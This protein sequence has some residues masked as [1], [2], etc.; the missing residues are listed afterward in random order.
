M[1]KSMSKLEKLG[2]YFTVKNNKSPEVL[3]P[4]GYMWCGVF[5]FIELL[6]AAKVSCCNLM[7]IKNPSNKKA[8]WVMG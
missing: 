3:L 7:L 6:N 5:V 2:S 1:G 8:T 4:P